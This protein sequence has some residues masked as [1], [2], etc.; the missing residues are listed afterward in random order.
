MHAVVPLVLSLEPLLTSRLNL[1]EDLFW[2][3]HHISKAKN[4][5]STFKRDGQTKA[6]FPHDLALYVGID[7]DRG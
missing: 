5:V 7:V 4:P 1:L 6:P 2:I 3:R